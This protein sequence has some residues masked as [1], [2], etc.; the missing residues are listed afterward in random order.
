M[1]P[2][3]AIFQKRLKLTTGM[4]DADDVDEVLL[5]CRRDRPAVA[6]PLAG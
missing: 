4:M 3:A 6:A 1:L 2:L 5:V